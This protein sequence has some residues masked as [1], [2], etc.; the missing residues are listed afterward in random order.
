MGRPGLHFDTGD[1]THGSKQRND[2]GA[3]IAEKRQRQTDDRHDEQTHP[4]VDDHLKG[5]HG[6]NSHADTG[7]EHRA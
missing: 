7:V 3:T 5:Q 2:G 4:D 1:K 6:G